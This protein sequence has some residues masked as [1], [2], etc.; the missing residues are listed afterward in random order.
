MKKK[1]NIGIALL[2][3]AALLIIFTGVA[4][5]AVA[6]RSRAMFYQSNVQLPS[7]DFMVL[8]DGMVDGLMIQMNSH[9]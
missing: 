7:N 3:T 4:F 8:W 6:I 1:R 9:Q 2:I 5:A